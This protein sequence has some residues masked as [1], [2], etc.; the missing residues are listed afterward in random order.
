[1][2][3]R[4]DPGGVQQDHPTSSSSGDRRGTGKGNAGRHY[5]RRAKATAL[6]LEDPAD[7]SLGKILPGTKQSYKQSVRFRTGPERTCAGTRGRTPPEPGSYPESP[8]SPPVSVEQ[9]S[10]Y[11]RAA[12]S[13][14]SFYRSLRS[15]T[16]KIYCLHA[17]AQPVIAHSYIICIKFTTHGKL[18]IT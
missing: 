2:V 5:R 4:C 6:N 17:P 9:C 8:R 1:M 11:S 14:I 16:A 7:T 3:R 12:I 10:F 13:Q 18:Y 15:E